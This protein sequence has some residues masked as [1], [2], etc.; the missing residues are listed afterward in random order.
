MTVEH[1]FSH[2]NAGDGG[3]FDLQDDPSTDP[4]FGQSLD[5][6]QEGVD[7]AQ[8]HPLRTVDDHGSRRVQILRDDLPSVQTPLKQRRFFGFGFIESLA[9]K[10][11]KAQTFYNLEKIYQIKMTPVNSI[12]SK[13]ITFQSQSLIS[14]FKFQNHRIGKKDGFQIFEGQCSIDFEDGVCGIPG[15]GGM[16]LF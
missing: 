11:G 13:N 1:D 4:G 16:P 3:L 9:Q 12:K 10:S 2:G 14:T 15:K 8:S 7:G 6:V 5:A